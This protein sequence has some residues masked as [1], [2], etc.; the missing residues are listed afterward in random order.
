MCFP[1]QLCLG[2]SAHHTV[3]GSS[4]GETLAHLDQNDT[5]AGRGDDP[6]GLSDFTAS[7]R[8]YLYG[9]EGIEGRHAR[10]ELWHLVMIISYKC[11]SA[12][13]Q[14][15]LAMDPG[16]STC[17]FEFPLEDPGGGL[18]AWR[19][20]LYMNDYSR[21]LHGNP[22]KGIPMPPDA[23]MFRITPYGTHHLTNWAKIIEDLV[24]TDA[25]RAEKLMRA[26]AHLPVEGVEHLKGVCLPDVCLLPEGTLVMVSLRATGEVLQCGVL[27]RT[28]CGSGAPMEVG[29]LVVDLK[30]HTV[31]P[32]EVDRAA[33]RR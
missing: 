16:E 8:T 31:V 24:H 7:G 4:G 1:P 29:P 11:T 20:H 21:R 28:H 14:A 13:I 9:D 12:E 23:C 6:W 2:L 18:D 17:V 15:I 19:I 26:I 27:M 30:I 25:A 22:K 3:L 32:V 10:E 33:R 5:G